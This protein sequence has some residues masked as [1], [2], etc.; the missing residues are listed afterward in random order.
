MAVTTVDQN[1]DQE[2]ERS[3]CGRAF[4]LIYGDCPTIAENTLIDLIKTVQSWSH[5]TIS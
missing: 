3:S 2:Q 1:A 4:C 5:T